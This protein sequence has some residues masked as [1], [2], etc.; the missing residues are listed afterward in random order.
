M[1]KLIVM[2]LAGLLPMVPA[3]S[4]NYGQASILTP[5]DFPFA[6]DGI[7]AESSENV[8]TVGVADLDM[9]DLSWARAQGTVRNLRDRRFD[10]YRVVWMDDKA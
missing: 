6:R 7:A 1:I 9:T 8:E 4:L 3:V 2:L 10:L 5:C